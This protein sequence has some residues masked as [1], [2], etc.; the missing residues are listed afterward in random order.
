MVISRSKE[1]SLPLEHPDAFVDRHIGE[2][3]GGKPVIRCAAGDVSYRELAGNVN[4]C[5][6]VLQHMGVAPGDGA[7]DF[8]GIIDGAIDGSIK[9]LVVA[10]DNPMMLAPGRARIE[11]ALKKLE[12]LIVIDQ[13]MTDTAQLADVVLA[14]VPAIAKEGTLT[15]ADHR[16]QRMRVA[17]AAQGAAQPAW[18]TLSQL[19]TR[20]AAKL[21][22]SESF[23]Y[24]EAAD[25]TEEITKQVEGY[26]RF[27]FYGYLGWGKGRAVSDD[28]PEA[29]ALQ[30]IASKPAAPAANGEV[31]LLTGRTLF[32]S[33]EGAALHSPDADKLHREDGVLVNQYDAVELGI[34]MGDSVVLRNGSDELSLTATLTNTV[35]RGS[36]FVSSY[37]DGGAVNRLLPFE[38]GSTAPVRVKLVK[39]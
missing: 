2:G 5:A 15:S 3:R 31:V 20:L 16:V 9:A 30:P 1:K 28:V 13:V 23:A 24:E 4:R 37:Y 22:A 17:Q 21:N 7:R 25:I 35:P 27:H 29:I 11:E 34:G 36:V 32:T 18:Q 10:G 6:H 33:L 14:D 39:P 26:Q 19:G 12:L 8:A 38:N